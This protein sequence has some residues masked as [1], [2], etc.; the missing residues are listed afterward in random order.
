MASVT[1][2]SERRNLSR[3]PA[4]EVENV[5]RRFGDVEALARVSLTVRQGEFFSLLGPSGCGKTTLLRIIGGLDVADEGTVRIGGVDMRAIPAHK[6]PVNTVFQSYALFPHLTVRDNVAFGLRMKRVAPVEIARRVAAVM[7][8]VEIAELADRKPAQLSGGQKQR[9]ALARAI[10]NEPQV[11]LLDEPLGALDLKLRKQLQVELLSL[12]RR[13]GITFIYVT[14]DQ[15]EAL[16]MSD[17]IAVMRAGR[18]EQMGDAEAL[19]ERPRNRFVGQFLGS[20]NLI[21]ATVKRREG[22]DLWV[23][24]EVGTLRVSANGQTSPA[25]QQSKFTLAIRPEKVSMFPATEGV[26]E[27]RFRVRVEELIYIGSET[28]YLLRA[29]SL[30]LRA[31]VMNVRVGSQG[32]DLGQ[33]AMVYLPPGGLIILDD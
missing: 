25:A 10:V 20:V 27:N 13:L 15:E 8:M 2:E 24:T 17:R 33:E 26:G 9:V 11:L 3:A 28:H 31:E 5:V 6:R 14:H 4:V 32:F 16:V 22:D 18:I 23:E 12:Q 30:T 7:E 1:T 19:Y 21:D 29:G